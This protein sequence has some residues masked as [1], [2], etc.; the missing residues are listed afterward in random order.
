M[1]T[2]FSA[3]PFVI[4]LLLAGCAPAVSATQ[5]VPSATEQASAAAPLST[6]IPTTADSTASSTSS[7][8]IVDTSQG[9]C[10]DNNVE[11]PCSETSFTGQD[12]QYTGNAP[13][14]QDNGDGTVTD[15]VTGLMWQQDPGAKMTYDEAVA[16]ASTFTFSGIPAVMMLSM[17]RRGLAQEP[18]QVQ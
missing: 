8:P 6:L 17:S 9:K 12:A 14:Y 10:Y 16:G 5:T 11:I 15:L 7:Y 2:K 18:R 13:R 3:I 4:A 1:K